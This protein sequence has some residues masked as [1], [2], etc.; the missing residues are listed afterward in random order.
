[1]R[2]RAVQRG[3]R[4]RV[5]RVH[6]ARP[7]VEIPEPRLHGEDRLVGPAVT[8]DV[9]KGLTPGG[10]AP[11]LGPEL[12]EGPE[13]EAQ[14]QETAHR[15]S[16]P[17]T[18]T[19]RSPCQETA[20]REQPEDVLGRGLP[21]EAD[22][23][24]RACAHGTGRPQGGKGA[25]TAKSERPR[26]CR[27]PQHRREVV[28]SRGHEVQDAVESADLLLLGQV[29]PQRA[30]APGPHR[31]GS[32][33]RPHESGATQPTRIPAGHA[34]GREGREHE[35]S[36]NHQERELERA[37]EPHEGQAEQSAQRPLLTGSA[38]PRQET[39]RNDRSSGRVGA[40]VPG[41]VQ[42]PR[43]RPPAQDGP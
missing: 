20:E 27:D 22:E 35:A 34:R 2:A 17:A 40:R 31:K 13:A 26:H 12:E 25:V 24:N 29:D 36:R 1:M 7:R 14:H 41:P 43:A 10:A 16:G 30:P 6:P 28:P 21:R 39:Q 23:T 3:E 18:R 42:G 37:C 4:S 8:L 33:R 9:G 32:D 11:T 38:E 19:R 15:P 5:A